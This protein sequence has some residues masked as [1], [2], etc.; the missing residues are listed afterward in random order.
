MANLK[1]I[2]AK[3][4][5][6]KKMGTVTRA[7]EAVSAVKMRKSQERALSSRAYAAT[8]LTILER[9]SGT[10]DLSRHA[11]MT[12]RSG[13]TAFIVI[14]S[15]KGLA[16]S[17]NSGVI[18]KAEQEIKDRNLEKT[19]VVIEAIGRRGGDHFIARGYDVRAK[20]ENVSDDISEADV[21]DVTD[22]ILKL[23]EQ[24][25]VGSAFVVYSNFL[26]TFE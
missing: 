18:R 12:D 1:S 26:S 3:I 20:H 14:T 5:S 4:L 16:G 6:S 23:R 25:E 21:R 11:L 17:L 19:D 2:K 22:K 10:A 24:G 7:M 13:K 9:V 8:A 15:D